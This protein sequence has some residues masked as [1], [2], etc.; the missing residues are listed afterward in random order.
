MKVVLDINV[1]ICAFFW[2]GL[3]HNL[4]KS[5]EKGDLI[6]C[7]TP[8]MLKELRNVLIRPFFSS[9]I[10]ERKTS[11]EELLAGL[12]ELTELHPDRKIEPI[13]KNDPDYDKVLSCAKFSEAKYII[14]GDPH[15][16]KLKNYSGI[17]ILTPRQFLNLIK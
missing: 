1:L 5:I 14:T 2:H 6:L 15:L 11:V 8:A 7:L 17:L 4:L 9:R 13:V 3:P 16:L 12:L 10:K